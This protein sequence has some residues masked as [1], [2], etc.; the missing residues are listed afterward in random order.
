M[1][2]F[3]EA[4]QKKPQDWKNACTRYK[5]HLLSIRAKVP[6]NWMRL[7]DADLHDAKILAVNRPSKHQL[8]LELDSATLT[9]SGVKFLWV[10]PSVINS[11][12]I[13]WEIDLANEG[14]INL[15]VALNSDSIRVI[16]DDVSITQKNPSLKT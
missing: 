6:A 2:F 11:Y 15:E 14:G 12:W 8:I 4:N 9:F 1:R 3:T 10:P 16:A 7:A 5:A 13:N